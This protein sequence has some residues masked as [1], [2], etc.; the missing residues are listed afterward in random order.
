MAS[1]NGNGSRHNGKASTGTALKT[2]SRSRRKVR[3]AILGVGNCASSLVQ[4]V[5]YYKDAKPGASIP[6][7]MHVE[8]GGYHIRDI[9]FSA[10]FDI[11]KEK[12]G[13]DLADAIFSGH[14]NTVKFSEVPHLGVKV[15]RGMTHDGL[16]KYLSEIITKAPG[17]TADIVKILKDTKTDVV[18]NY[19]PVGSEMA[20]KRDAEQILEAGGAM[21]NCMPV[22]IAREDYWNKRF[23]DAGVPI[24]GDDIK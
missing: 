19:L 2:S 13:K 4:G 20:P 15:E 8:L 3:V 1:K 12:V 22:F 10:A 6:G 7:L 21:V 16:G 18:V 5:E 14:N 24:I 11:D 23:Q 17:E 9:E